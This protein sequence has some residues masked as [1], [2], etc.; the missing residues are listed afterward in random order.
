MVNDTLF[1]ESAS[2]IVVSTAEEKIQVG[3]AAP[4]RR[5]WPAT[6]IGKTGSFGSGRLGARAATMPGDR[7]REACGNGDRNEM[8]AMFDKFAT[9]V[10]SSASTGTERR[11]GLSRP[12]SLRSWTGKRG[13]DSPIGTRS[14]PWAEGC[15]RL[16]ERD[17]RADGR[18]YASGHKRYST[19]GESKR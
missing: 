18:Q 5:V 15:Q 10:V 13:H 8:G 17:P 9:N 2:R 4:K 11:R 14:V 12:D 3:L 6:V 16:F 7:G 19:A 1:G